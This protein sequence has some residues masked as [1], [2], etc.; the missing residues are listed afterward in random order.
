[1]QDAETRCSQVNSNIE[2]NAANKTENK[3]KR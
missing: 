1:M 3:I 2:F